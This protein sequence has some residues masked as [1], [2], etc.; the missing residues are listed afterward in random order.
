MRDVARRESGPKETPA[1]TSAKACADSQIWKGVWCALRP[2]KSKAGDANSAD[3]DFE[4]FCGRAHG[5]YLLWMWGGIDLDNR[6]G[7]RREC[8]A[9]VAVLWTVSCCQDVIR[10]CAVG[11]G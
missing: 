9:G 3:R 4:G 10:Q 11:L 5:G 8:I 1:P 6:R 2:C 7:G